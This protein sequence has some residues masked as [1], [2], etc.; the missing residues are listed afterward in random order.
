MQKNGIKSA[1]T[2]L[3]LLTENCKWRAT[4]SLCPGNVISSRTENQTALFHLRS[5]PAKHVGTGHALRGL[6]GINKP[7]QKSTT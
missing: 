7:K 3:R 5:D 4:T 6:S 1:K 2:T